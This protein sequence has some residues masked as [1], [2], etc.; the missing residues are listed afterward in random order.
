MKGAKGSFDCP[1]HI[2]WKLRSHSQ[3]AF[4]HGSLLTELQLLFVPRPAIRAGRRRCPICANKEF[5]HAGDRRHKRQAKL[6]IAV[7]YEGD[8][9]VKP[10]D[11]PKFVCVS[12][13]GR[14]PEAKRL[15]ERLCR[16]SIDS[17]RL[18]IAPSLP[19]EAAAIHAGVVYEARIRNTCEAF[20]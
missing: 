14:Y 2:V 5:I 15:G 20:V 4:E 13:Q 11:L 6:Q 10:S 1:A 16:V 12:Y 18:W 9:W 17:N 19:F 7:L 8:P 3:P